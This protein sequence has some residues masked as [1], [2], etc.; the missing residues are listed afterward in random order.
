MHGKEA[1][2]VLKIEAEAVGALI[3]RIDKKFDE[4]IGLLSECRGRVIV[5]GM[6]KG[7]LVGQKISATLSSTGTPSLFLH[8]A[9]AIHGDLGRVTKEDVVLAISNSGETEEVVRLLP[10]IKKIG[11]RLIALT[12]NPRSTLGRHSDVTLDVSVKKEAC[13]LG[14]APTASTTATLAMGD[15]IAVCLLKKKGFRQEDFAFYHP[16]GALGKRLLLKVEDIMRRGAA[17]PVVKEDALVRDVLL[18][19]TEARAGA[20][21]VVD[22]SGQLTGIFT[23]GDLRRHV[24]SDKHLVV[25][26]VKDVMTKAPVTIPKDHLASE[27]LRILKDRRIDEVPI[28]DAKH[29]PI[30][31]LDVQDLLKA[32]LV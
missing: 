21:S 32:G 16:G 24:E 28:V 7:G 31:M 15:A 23:D 4:A 20:A 18:K 14:L 27:A 1:R 30:G 12:G 8:S 5:T 11:V 10:L 17:N 2:K 19:I 3:R 25:R 22:K 26:K 9:E 6:G 13:P 29:R